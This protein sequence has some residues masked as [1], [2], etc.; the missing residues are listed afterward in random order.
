MQAQEELAAVSAVVTPNPNLSQC[1]RGRQFRERAWTQQGPGVQPTG[2]V[3][4]LVPLGA[5]PGR[6]ARPERSAGPSSPPQPRSGFQTPLE[7]D[8][9][10]RVVR[11]QGSALPN[12][13]CVYELVLGADGAWREKRS[14]KGRQFEMELLPPTLFLAVSPRR[15]CPAWGCG[16]P[17]GGPQ[18]A[19]QSLTR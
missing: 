10:D 19:F 2:E 9:E 7:V 12:L 18:L 15:G 6:G 1:Q 4:P 11:S 16:A 8:S 5:H 13:L 14:Q 3:K 17:P